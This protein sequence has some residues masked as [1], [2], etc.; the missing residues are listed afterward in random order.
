[1][2][3]MRSRLHVRLGSVLAAAGA[4]VLAGCSGSDGG[5][6]SAASDVADMF[7]PAIDSWVMPLDSFHENLAF[8]TQVASDLVMR[9]C[10]Q[11]QGYDYPGPFLD[12]DRAATATQNSW[13]WRLFDEDIART[14]GYSQEMR[15]LDPDRL[16]SDRALVDALA[17]EAPDAVAT[18]RERT[19]S[20]IPPD[21][22]TAVNPRALGAAALRATV[23]DADV[24]ASVAR[25]QECMAPQGIPDLPD[26]PIAEMPT[27]SLLTRFGRPAASDELVEVTV[28]AEEIEVAVADARCRESSGYART[29][30]E[31]EWDRELEVVADNIDALERYRD[32]NAR[33]SAELD[34]VI[35][36]NGG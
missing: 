20:A 5:E 10:M 4:L 1:M 15:I 35:A 25:W 21:D 23:Q 14:W 7:T 29:F 36:A 9:A 18:C 11:E 26:D 13:Q 2:T 31:E 19:D 24:R 28:G 16:R 17:E 33:R 27:P 30:Y 32:A 12:P 8:K 34:R 22:E 3:M 6:T